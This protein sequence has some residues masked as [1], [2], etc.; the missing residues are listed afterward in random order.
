MIGKPWSQQNAKKRRLMLRATCYSPT[1]KVDWYS[2]EEQHREVFSQIAAY[3][4]CAI[5]FILFMVLVWYV[6][7]VNIN[8]SFATL[9]LCAECRCQTLVNC[10]H[11]CVRREQVTL[12]LPPTPTL[13]LTLPLT[14]TLTLSLSPTLTLTLNFTLTSIHL[15]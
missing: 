14:L 7:V 12:T 2:S 5:T 1:F 10:C 13:T 6:S 9:F 15:L 4:D 8:I 11:R 3:T